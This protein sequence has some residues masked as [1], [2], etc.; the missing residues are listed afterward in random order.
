MKKVICFLYFI[1]IG[2][3]IFFINAVSAQTPWRK[4]LLDYIDSRLTKEDGGYGWPDQPD[5]HLTPTFAVT[6]I[7]YTID[8]LPKDKAQLA[9]FIKTHHPQKGPNKEAGGSGSELRDLT[10]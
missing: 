6:G 3:N 9:T 1:F 8:E 10:Y 2:V 7:L 5:S 4:A